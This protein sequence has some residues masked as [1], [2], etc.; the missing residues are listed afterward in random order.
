[1]LSTPTTVVTNVSNSFSEG[2]THHTCT[3]LNLHHRLLSV[4]RSISRLQKS[5]Q[6]SPSQVRQHMAVPGALGRTSTY[7]RAIGRRFGLINNHINRVV[8]RTHK[9]VGGHAG[10]PFSS[11]SPFLP[12]LVQLPRYNKV[13]YSCRSR[14]YSSH[15]FGDEARC[16]M[17]G[18]RRR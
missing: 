9:P 13:C 14:S 17:A 12:L 7:T 16:K 3:V 15:V 10:C 2:L 18:C 8:G 6:V 1:M 5:C 11:S 4:T